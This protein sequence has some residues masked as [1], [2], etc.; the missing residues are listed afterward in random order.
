MTN[1]RSMRIADGNLVVSGN[2]G[3]V[4]LERPIMAPMRAVPAS[5]VQ[6]ETFTGEDFED[7]L[8]RA[9]RLIQGKYANVLPSTEEFIRQRREEEAEAEDRQP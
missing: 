6:R 5:E 3:A 1:K 7:A 8:D 2:I 4:S 9:S